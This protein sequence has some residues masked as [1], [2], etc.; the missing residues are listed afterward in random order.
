MTNTNEMKPTAPAEAPDSGRCAV[1]ALL[2]A[3]ELTKIKTVTRWTTSDGEDHCSLS[4]A[5]YHAGQMDKAAKA[6]AV[7][8]SGGS[9][10][11]ALRAAEW[12]YSDGVPEVLER[13]TKESRLV[14]EHWQCRDTPGY[15]VR[16]FTTNRDIY[17]HG[18]AGCWSGSYGSRVSLAD[19]TRYAAHMSTDFSPNGAYQ[20]RPSNSY[21]LSP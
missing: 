19:L 3:S 21:K 11:D 17:V 5:E 4:A 9:I 8:E 10:A 16:H 12:V 15:Q 6:N 14:I 13:V 18:N 2:G 7:L 1:D 20:P